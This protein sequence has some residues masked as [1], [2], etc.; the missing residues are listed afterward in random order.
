MSA[1][2]V[3][4]VSA[5]AKYSSTVEEDRNQGNIIFAGTDPLDRDCQRVSFSTEAAAT[6]NTITH[7]GEYTLVTKNGT[8]RIEATTSVLLIRRT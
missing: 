8:V 3:Y 5:L 6:D 4:M 2:P 1:P 7:V